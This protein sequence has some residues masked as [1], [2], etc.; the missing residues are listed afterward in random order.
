MT[1]DVDIENV[2]GILEGSASIEPGLNAV[3]A[4][5]WQGKSS[6]VE[7]LETG[8]GV[9]S[10][11]TEGKDRG[12]VR[13]ELPD[14]TIEV[15]LVRKGTDVHRRG[16][17]YLDDEYDAIRAELFACLDETNEVRRAVRHGENLEEVLLWPLD[18]QNIDERIADLKREREQVESELAQATEARKRLP[19]VEERVRQLESELS[20]LRERHD[21]LTNEGDDADPA[22]SARNELARARSERDRKATRIERLED[23]I[24]RTESRL[25]ESRTELAGI[26]VGGD[27]GTEAELAD[28]RAELDGLEHDLEVLQS[29]YTTTELVLEEGRLDMVT[30]VNRG[31]AED[32]V[33]CW[34][35]GSEVERSD[36]ETQLEDLGD[37]VAT[38][39]A[40]VEEQREV[41]DQL[42]ARREE[43][44]RSRRRERDLEAE[45][46]ELEDKLADQRQQ[47]AEARETRQSAR[48]RIEELS[49]RVDETVEEITDVESDIKYREAELKEARDERDSLKRR[50]DR[51]E[52]LT[53][54][55]ES[56]RE[57]IE[58]LRNRKDQ[59]K[60]ETREAFEGAMRE[61]LSRFDAG[62]ETARLT[63]EFELVVAR[64]GQEASLAALSEGELELLGFVAALAGYEAFDVAGTV[65][66]MLVDGVGG[67]DD[68]N[69]HTLVQ[70]LRERTEYLVFTA[71]P[72]HTDFDGTE[73]D[74]G[75]WTIA[76]DR[77]A[78]A[79]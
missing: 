61:V 10:Q 28:A 64:D 67:L 4:A 65:P 24:E 76:S 68:R 17:P 45:V 23:R 6:F 40:A 8:L 50:A 14:R 21:T 13:L 39:S 35:C 31:L 36:V 2:A 20:D 16:E 37:R 73:I 46:A 71:Y 9:S 52:T 15:E 32:T 62:F 5:N 27:D 41:V 33:A 74:P 48:E 55:R 60:Y 54:E 70:Y 59:I 11:L 19:S 51:V 47:L 38:L 18:F 78:P 34:T 12:S 42:E 44:E 66:V 69:H 29:V 43:I 79:R 72:E 7:A 3:R 57:E 22:Q 49:D 63:P 26:E 1:W 75:E 30:D 77:S 25:D 53:E 56:L 58:M